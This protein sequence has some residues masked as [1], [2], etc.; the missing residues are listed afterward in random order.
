VQ[1]LY[2]KIL[3]TCWIILRNMFLYRFESDNLTC[4]EDLTFVERAELKEVIFS[5]SIVV[6]HTYYV[7]YS[8]LGMKDFTIS[9]LFKYE[10]VHDN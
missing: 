9:L 7:F 6:S 4:G 8:S 5:I 2:V 3:P 1:E 10:Q